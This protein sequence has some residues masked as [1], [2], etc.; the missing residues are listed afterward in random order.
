MNKDKLK[1][2][3]KVFD[4]VLINASTPEI[5]ANNYLHILNLDS[6]SLEKYNTSKIEKLWL[7]VRFRLVA[8]I[9]ILHS[10]FDGEHYCVRQ[11]NIKSDVLFVSHLTNSQQLL[12]EQDAYFGC[13][14]NQLLE[15]GVSSSIVLMKHAKVSK[16]QVLNSWTNSKTPRFVLSPSLDF[17]SEIRIYFAQ[18]KSKNKLQ[19]ILKNLQTDKIITKDILLHQ[20]SSKTI[21]TIRVAK[22]VENIAEQTG[23]KFIITTYEGHAWERLV[24]Y[25]VRKQNPNVKCF[26]YQHAAVFK[27]QHA[28][29]RMLHKR[30]NPD[31]IL[32]SGMVA[33][34]ILEQSWLKEGKVVCVGSPKHLNLISSSILHKNQSCLVVP[35]GIIS[36]CLILFKLSLEYARQHKSQKFIWRLHPLLSFDNLK[37][38]ST[39]FDDLPDNIVL[40]E[41]DLDKDIQKCNSVLYR[42]STAVVS[43]IN[44]GLKP[45]YYQQSCG[46]L[47]IDPIYTY[48]EGKSI[49]RSQEELGLALTQDIGIKAMR[50]L[51]NFAQSFYKPL[52]VKALLKELDLK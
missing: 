6:E 3:C 13:L 34:A 21:S 15:Q 44:L 36:E 42:G 5:T 29:K 30:Y 32:T 23:A 17:L 52:E 49:V 33:K 41:S 47:N 8:I 48:D 25:S 50:S 38:K 2:L 51:Q 43:A 39:I 20:L 27:H 28:A 31:V 35:E 40:S 12:Q 26:G 18:R 22:Q 11:N 1:F 45:I 14:P 16:Q 19:S 7:M 9:R 37:D 46:E 24:Y 4:Q 10:I